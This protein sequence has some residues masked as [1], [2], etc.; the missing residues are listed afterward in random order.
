MADDAAL[1]E[2]RV[3]D[4]WQ[5]FP[6]EHGGGLVSPCRQAVL[7]VHCEEVTD[8]T[9]LPNLSRMLAGFVTGHHRPIITQDLLPFSLPGALGF[10]Y[11]YA[12][13]ERAIRV[14]IVGNPHAW[15]FINFQAPL[16]AEER[17]RATVDEFVQSVRLW[18]APS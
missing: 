6:D 11:Q 17:F 8:P 15:A 13:D 3:P 4:G 1:C 9:E 10:A 7:H 18:E 14:W 12:Q 16:Q 2:F 5:F